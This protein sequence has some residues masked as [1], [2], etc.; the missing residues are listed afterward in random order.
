MVT[1]QDPGTGTS[2]ALM[3]ATGVVVNLEDEREIA[4]AY[5]DLRKLKDQ[6][7]ETERVLREAMRYRSEVLATK[8]FHI[9]GVGKV[10]LRGSTRVDWPDPQALEEDLRGVGCPED[11]IR[12]IV[13]ETV[14]WK[15]DGNRARRAAGAN[16]AYAE[17]IE[18]HKRTIEPLP[19]VLIT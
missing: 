13:V 19:S 3:P 6:V 12:E 10:E 4:I 8:T 5:R 2:V 7:L 14:S 16:P 15:V 18:K 9:E 1:E 17:V 11:V